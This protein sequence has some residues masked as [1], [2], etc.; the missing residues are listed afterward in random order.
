MVRFLIASHGRFAEG[1]YDT[2]V[3]VMG[4]RDGLSFFGAYTDSANDIE[5]V[6]RRYVEGIEEGDD[7]VVL[8]DVFG[9]SVNN[10]FMKYIGKDHFYLVSGISLPLLIE[11]VTNTEADISERIKEAVGKAGHFVCNCTDMKL[12]NTEQDNF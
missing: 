4:K 6:A 9:G 2:F 3:M 5:E 12:D 1:L 7:L 10:E 8:T 11:M